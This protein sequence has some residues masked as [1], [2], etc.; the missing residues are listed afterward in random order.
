M[1]GKTTRKKLVPPEEPENDVPT[2]KDLE[3]VK[4]FKRLSRKGEEPSTRDLA[5]ALGIS[6]TAVQWRLRH[7]Q[8]KGLLLRRPVEAWGPYE[9]SPEGVKWIAMAG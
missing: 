2:R 4:A 6:Q 9:L 3:T 5:D 7:C 8:A 1:A